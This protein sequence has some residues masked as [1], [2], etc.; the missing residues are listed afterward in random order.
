MLAC[1]VP[2]IL[3]GCSHLGLHF[4]EVILGLQLELKDSQELIQ[5][6]E[7]DKQPQNHPVGRGKGRGESII[8]CVKV[9]GQGNDIERIGTPF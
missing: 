2:R 5:G 8:E 3:L 7:Q 9:S 6:P 1:Q 4:K